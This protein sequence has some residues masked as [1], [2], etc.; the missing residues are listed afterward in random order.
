MPLLSQQFLPWL[1]PRLLGVVYFAAFWSLLVQVRGL[2]G[3]HGILPIASYLA[4]IREGVRKPDYLDFPTIFWLNSGDRALVGGCLA[5][6]LL[7]ILLIAG[8]PP[9]PLLILL[10]LLYLSYVSVGQEFLAY[11]WDT[12]LLEVGFMTI[13]LPLASPAP[14]LVVF[15]Y[16]FFLFR[17]M[18]SAGAVKLL[19]GDPIWRSLTALCY[20]Y[21]TQPIPNRPAWYA[22]QMP[23]SIQK[24]STLLT[25][26][27]EVG[28]PILALGPEPARLACLALMILLQLL[29]AGTGNYGFFNLLTIVMCLP[30]LDDGL[31]G[32]FLDL[33]QALPYEPAVIA[34]S[35]VF[36]IFIILNL[37]QLVLLVHRGRWLIR[38][39]MRI[40][41]F[42]I[43]NHYGLFA[44]MTTERYEFVIE[45][46]LDGNQWQEYEFRWKPGDPQ[47]PPRQA[48]PHMPRLDWQMWFAALDPNRL[49]PWLKNFIVRLL[50]GHRE[51]TSLLAVNPFPDTPPTYIRV[52]VYRYNFSDY[53][54]RRRE[55]IWWS[56]TLIGRFQPMKLQIHK[57]PA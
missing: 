6:L 42:M 33:P 3:S 7:S 16:R 36:G 55:S 28:A 15:A 13:F 57:Q 4:A 23:L 47:R 14:P 53:H 21:Q 30:L 5:G 43:T 22:H 41:Q 51:V 35:V 37:C 9:V 45:G 17:F 29:I 18:I 8:A 31:A 24:L 27:L 48:A 49:E 40:S 54:Q 25:L 34:V 19:S 52:T 12:L 56:R 50:Q 10:W 20:H 44:V 39:L 2:F 32:R 1:F 11:Q 46:S 38:P 26:L